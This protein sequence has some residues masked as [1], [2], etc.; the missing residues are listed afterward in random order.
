MDHADSKSWLCT[1]IPPRRE[2]MTK[3]KGLMGNEKFN[4]LVISSKLDGF[5]V[6]TKRICYVS[7]DEGKTAS[8]TVEIL[9]M[10][11]ENSGTMQYKVMCTK[12]TL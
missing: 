2:S 7:I 8:E 11:D 9:T 1:D 10:L 3:F 12:Y 6:E 5:G 4:P